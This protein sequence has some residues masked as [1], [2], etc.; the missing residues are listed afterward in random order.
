[1]L[2]SLW[3]ESLRIS[4]GKVVNCLFNTDPVKNGKEGKI[5]SLVQSDLKRVLLC[6]NAT[7]QI[8]VV[9]TIKGVFFCSHY[10]SIWTDLGLVPLN[11]RSVTHTG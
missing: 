10:M 6:Y 2:S 1:M 8:S 3:A 11:L 4:T 5:G 7:P 9:Y